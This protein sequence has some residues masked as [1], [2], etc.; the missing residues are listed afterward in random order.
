MKDLSEYEKKHSIGK[1]GGD[2]FVN[3]SI[4]V[5]TTPFIGIP[6]VIGKEILFSKTKKKRLLI[7]FLKDQIKKQKKSEKVWDKQVSRRSFLK[8]LAAVS[9][10][11]KRNL[12]L[13]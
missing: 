11:S 9:V 7:E 1:R 2:L 13:Y 8:G 5:S 12:K 6:L 10:I 4:I 3:S